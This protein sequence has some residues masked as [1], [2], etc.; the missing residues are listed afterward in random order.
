MAKRVIID[1]EKFFDYVLKRIKNENGEYIYSQF[2]TDEFIKKIIFGNNGGPIVNTT[3][4]IAQ[5]STTTSTTSTT[6]TSTTTLS[7]NFFNETDKIIQFTLSDLLRLNQINYS[8]NPNT[9]SIANF[10]VLNNPSI[11]INLVLLSISDLNN[12]EV[13]NFNGYELVV[14]FN[15]GGASTIYSNEVELSQFRSLLNTSIFWFNNV[16]SVRIRYSSVGTT[17][18]TTSTSTTTTSSSTTSTSTTTTTST[19]STTS[20]S[21]TT[22]TTTLPPSTSTTSTS[23]STTTTTS[24]QAGISIDLSLLNILNDNPLIGYQLFNSSDILIDSG[25]LGSIDGIYTI[26][27]FTLPFKLKLN[28]ADTNAITA[29]GNYNIKIYKTFDQVLNNLLLDNNILVPYSSNSLTNISDESNTRNVLAIIDQLN[30]VAPTTTTTSTTSTTTSTSTSTTTTTTTTIPIVRVNFYDTLQRGLTF[31]L[32]PGNHSITPGLN[33]FLDI[34]QEIYTVDIIGDISNTLLQIKDKNDVIISN[35]PTS[36]GFLIDTSN[37]RSLSVNIVPTTTSTTST[38]TSSTTSTTSS[39]STTTSSSS[40]TTTTT[41]TLPP[42]DLN[43]IFEVDQDE[44]NDTEYEAY[45]LFGN[46]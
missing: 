34:P 41:T 26:S 46:S 11:N 1:P 22:T 15:N 20:T 30:D 13:S 27:N 25:S 32:T 2:R 5:T 42:S 21:T 8:I 4:T 37:I 6:T 17:T 31:N 19:T 39:T 14:N 24:T 18:S 7:V 36:T 38:S 29:Q 3:T 23:S 9:N 40:S 28:V 35:N 10:N 43:L 45:F 16:I 12:N 33:G 44:L